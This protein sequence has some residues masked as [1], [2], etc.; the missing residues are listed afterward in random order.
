MTTQAYY[1]WVAGGRRWQLARPIADMVALAKRY[2]IAVLGTIGADDDS[3][4]Q[5][6]FPEDHCPF[7]FTFWPVDA[8]GWV[9]AGD[10][11]N[12]NGLGEAL[13]RDARAGRTPW[14]KYMNFANR[15]YGHADGFRSA[16]WNGDTHVHLSCRSDWTGRGI[17]TYD[18]F[19][20]EE[21]MSAQSDE[22]LAA[23]AN[24]NPKLASTGGVVAPVVWRIRDEAWQK[25]ISADLRL[26]LTAVTEMAKAGGADAA[27]VVAE[28]RAQG[29]AIRAQLTVQ[30]AE[31]M[32]ALR[33]EYDAEVAG[34]RAE[35]A[36]RE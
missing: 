24:G 2:G 4:L 8:Y 1:D 18:P 28:L 10:F 35:L 16:T 6:D 25:Q 27:P 19:N 22:I 13:L 32:A 12:A 31:E 9:C 7:S 15:S 23:M 33:R 30:H 29:D 36:A 34:L 14:L 21:D 26:A 3:H 5:A 17:G 20:P 11:A